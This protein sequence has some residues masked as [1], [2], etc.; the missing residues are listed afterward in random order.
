MLSKISL[1]SLTILIVSTIGSIRTLPTTAFFGSSLVFFYLLAAVIFLI[2][3]AFISAEFSSRN[4]S[5]GG[6]F[7]WVRQAFGSKIGLLAI[8]LQWINTMVWYPTMLLFIAST[9]SYLINPKLADDKLFLLLSS[10]A[11]FWSIT[12]LNLKGIKSSVKLNSFCGT[13]GT[14]IP[15]CALIFLGGWLA[16]TDRTIL[17]NPFT[18]NSLIPSFDLLDNSNA[19]VTIMASFL[20]MELAGVHVGDIKDPQKSFPKAVAYSVL[21]L[22]GT[23]IL[24]ALSIAYIVPKPDIHFADGVMQTFVTFLNVFKIPYLV[25]VLAFLIVLGGAGGSINWI[26]SPAKGLMHATEE[27]FLPP[28]FLA[29][30]KNGVSYRILVLQAI[31]VTIFC[32]ALHFVSNVN[33]YYWFLMALST[34]LYMLMYVLLFLAA[35]KLKRPEKGY[36][37]P[38]GFRVASCIAGLASCVITIIVGFQPVPG[39]VIENKGHY[40]LMIVV[41]FSLMLVPVAFLWSYQ[42]KRKGANIHDLTNIVS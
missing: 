22:L 25:P 13:V 4:I 17:V 10:L 15:I 3:V 35:L 41:G 12:F 40:I 18:W 24:G 7:H 5:E 9:T 26:L 42:K 31:V 19:L 2:P 16:L 20:G 1:F 38:K 32:C 33:A 36:K 39:V 29:K 14:L 30:N 21:I 23:L 28:F 8:W 11:T 37:I 6:V 34:G 27:G